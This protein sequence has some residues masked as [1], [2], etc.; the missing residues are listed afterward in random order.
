MYKPVELASAE[1]GLNEYAF[2]LRRGNFV[3]VSRSW[4]GGI[5]RIMLFDVIYKE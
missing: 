4:E 2:F 5:D 1:K 3:K